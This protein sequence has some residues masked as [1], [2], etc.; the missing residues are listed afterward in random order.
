V[1]GVAAI[2]GLAK[3]EHESFLLFSVSD[4]ADGVRRSVGRAA[5]AMIQTIRM[6]R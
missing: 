2:L 1:V 3:R 6:Q 5:V 4:A